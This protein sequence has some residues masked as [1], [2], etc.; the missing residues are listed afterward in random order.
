MM[1]PDEKSG[2][3]A[4]TARQSPSLF[5]EEA[6]TFLALSSRSQADVAKLVED[7]DEVLTRCREDV[8]ALALVKAHQHML[9]CDQAWLLPCKD[10]TR[11]E[12]QR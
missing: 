7:G 11:R 3:V 2:T 9:L 12:K 4:T 8:N 10:A 1:V 6:A 5:V